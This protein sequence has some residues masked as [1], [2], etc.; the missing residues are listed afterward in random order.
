MARPC[1]KKSILAA[2]LFSPNGPGERPTRIHG[3]PLAAKL[4]VTAS[5]PTTSMMHRV[6][7]LTSG[8]I[9][10]SA[11]VIGTSKR[12]LMMTGRTAAKRTQKTL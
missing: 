10:A 9:E 1:L 5:N 2:M 12:A 6:E 7:S 3:F 4:R 11:S 8:L